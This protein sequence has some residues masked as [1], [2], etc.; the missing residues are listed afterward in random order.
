[1]KPFAARTVRTIGT[2]T[3]TNAADK[4]PSPNSTMRS[5]A[6]CLFT[7]V[8]KNWRIAHGKT[9]RGAQLIRSLC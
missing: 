7:V 8:I 4:S 2:R 9:R 3:T 5:G 1:M 6:F